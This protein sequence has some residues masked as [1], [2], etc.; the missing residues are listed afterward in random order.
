[1]IAYATNIGRLAMVAP[2]KGETQREAKPKSSLQPYQA[3][4]RNMDALFD[5]FEIGHDGKG[6]DYQQ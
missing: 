5:V 4:R 3:L 6:H 1:L 2:A